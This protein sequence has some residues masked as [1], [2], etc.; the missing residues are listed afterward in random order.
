MTWGKQQNAIQH[1]AH[2]I[3]NPPQDSWKKHPVPPPANAF[4]SRDKR[5]E[6]SY[7]RRCTNLTT[8]CN[9]YAHSSPS[10]P[11]KTST[12]WQ[13]RRKRR[14]PSVSDLSWTKLITSI[15]QRKQIVIQRLSSGNS[16]FV[17]RHLWDWDPES[18]SRC[19]HRG[20]ATE[21][22]PPPPPSHSNIQNIL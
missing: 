9:F 7:I 4:C 2:R 16:F 3:F 5:V 19:L 11:W 15:C 12:C 8:Q 18:S 10:R 22:S 13:G 20:S 1:A 14:M 6:Y 21:K 17:P